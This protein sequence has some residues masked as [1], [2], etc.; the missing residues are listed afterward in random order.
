MYINTTKGFKLTVL[1]AAIRSHYRVLNQWPDD[2]PIEGEEHSEEIL[3]E[4]SQTETETEVESD[5]IINSPR[6]HIAILDAA[7]MKVQTA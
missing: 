7:A 2:E 6:H 5:I 3:E 4:E 1:G